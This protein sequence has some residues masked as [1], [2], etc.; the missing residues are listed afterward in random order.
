M[1]KHLHFT[2]VK[3]FRVLP[4]RHL[5]MVSFMVLL[6]LF[7]IN[8][9]LAQS[10]KEYNKLLIEMKASSDEGIQL[11]GSRLEKLA[12]QLQST[13]YVGDEIKAFGGKAPVCAIV[14]GASVAKIYSENN[15][16][17]S[18]ELLTIK[19][20]QSGLPVPIN[21]SSLTFFPNLKYIRLLCEYSFTT[22]QI[23]SMITGSNT[24]IIVCYLVS[25]PG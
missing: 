14:D 5:F 18:V 9:T 10:L 21:L 19:I 22:T 2:N 1:E 17:N 3:A 23:E 13:V 11:Q 7:S 8:F 12:T 6:S 16:F 4:Q 15:Y 20:D 25:M 24:A